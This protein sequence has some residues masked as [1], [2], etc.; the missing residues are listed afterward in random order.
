[1]ALEPSIDDAAANLSD[2]FQRVGQ[3]TGTSEQDD[4]LVSQRLMRLL[5]T[6]LLEQMGLLGP[7]QSGSSVALLD[8]ACGTGVVTQEVQAALEGEVLKRSRFVCADSSAGMVGQVRQKAA[9]EGWVKVE[10]M[11]ADARV[12]LEPLTDT[13]CLPREVVE[14]R[15]AGGLVQPRCGGAGASH[16]PGP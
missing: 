9:T 7:R 2:L 4:A 3:G 1:M 11:V 14:P 8:N 10:A 15:A 5:A 13:D 16:H 12:S 6:P